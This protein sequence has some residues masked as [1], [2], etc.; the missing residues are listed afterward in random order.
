MEDFGKVQHHEALRQLVTHLQDY[1]NQP[2][3]QSIQEQF[4]QAL[5]SIYNK[6]SSSV[7][8]HFSPAWRE[9]LKEL[10][11]FGEFGDELTLLIRNIIEK[12][13]IT[14]ATAVK[15]LQDLSEEVNGTYENLSQINEG[16]S[17]FNI[18]EDELEKDECE[19]GLIIPRVYVKDNMKS[20][21]KELEELEKALLVFSEVSTGKR[22]PLKIR[23]ISSSELSVFLNYIPEIAAC[24]SFA[25]ERIVQLYK[26]L[27]EI[28]VLRNQLKDKNVP[29]DS[30]QSLDKYIE[31]QIKP[32]LRKL[33]KETVEKYYKGQ[34]H[35][36]GRANELEIEL[37]TT[38]HK[39]ANRIDRGL[40]IE[41][42]TPSLSDQ[43]EEDNP[44]KETIEYIRK[45]ASKIEFLDHD[46]EPTLF[47]EDND[48]PESKE[49]D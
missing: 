40:N 2:Q 6:L 17:Y 45:L 15:K 22:E 3:N 37:R 42:R 41:I 18:G 39:L 20:F 4:S 10:G 26:T 12:N 35:Q 5:E 27:L 30:L 29:K 36:E 38:L 25:I 44:K 43:D 33:A 28:K 23:N 47:L 46:G 1:A 34:E 9:T 32:E 49:K 14:P 24:L 16:L 8:N 31:E 11:I 19:V 48:K 13:Q 7:T 21:G